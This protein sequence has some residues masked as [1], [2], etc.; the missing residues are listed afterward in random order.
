MYL[1]VIL[2]IQNNYK[3]MEIQIPLFAEAEIGGQEYLPT[4]QAVAPAFKTSE[5]SI[6][7]EPIVEPQTTQQADT[8]KWYNE[9]VVEKL[10]SKGLKIENDDI[11]LP[12]ETFIEK[13]NETLKEKNISVK[14]LKEIAD[15]VDQYDKLKNTVDKYGELTDE[16]LTRLAIDRKYGNGYYDK[17]K[18]INVESLDAKE[19]LWQKYQLDN[20]DY[21]DIEYLRRRFE[22]EFNAKYADE[23]DPDFSQRALNQ[24]SKIAKRELAA[25]KDNIL[26]DAKPQLSTHP[27]VDEQAFANAYFSK[28]DETLASPKPLKFTSGDVEFYIAPNEAELKEIQAKMD[29]LANTLVGRV[30]VNS[31]QFQ[32]LYELNAKQILMDR[33]IS[34]AIKSGVAKYQ[35]KEVLARMKSEPAV[36]TNPER[37]AKEYDRQVLANSLANIL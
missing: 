27:K 18:S 6:I 9:R 7:V 32:H 11:I 13:I 1:F 12:E 34:E 19:A 16:E 29:S 24:D 22:K 36:I 30:D 4:S 37:Q 33:I 26:K 23:E 8:E 14:E 21:D 31:I 17:V 25:Y 5:A 35:E 10:A 2:R 20:K 28:V 3:N 15:L